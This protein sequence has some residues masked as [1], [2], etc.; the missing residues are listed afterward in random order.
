MKNKV[1]NTTFENML[2]ILI[3][4]SVLAKPANS[5]RLT[6]LEVQSA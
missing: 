4:M 5:D 6:A 1:F 2:R 3:L